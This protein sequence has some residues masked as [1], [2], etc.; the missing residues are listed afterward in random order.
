[1]TSEVLIILTNMP[2]LHI[3]KTLAN[4]IVTAKVAAC[5]NILAPCQSFYLWENKLEDATEIPLLIKTT[6]SAYPTLE[7]MIQE[8]HPYELPEIIALP[9]TQGEPHYLQWVTKMCQPAIDFI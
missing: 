8:I 9:I 3:A 7:K 1:M 5:V 6:K 2:D 4:Q